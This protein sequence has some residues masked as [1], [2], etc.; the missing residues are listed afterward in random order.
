M[1]G[2]FIAQPAGSQTADSGAGITADA[3]VL[4]DAPPTISLPA[5]HD[6]CPGSTRG[7]A[8]DTPAVTLPASPGG[9]V[10]QPSVPVATLASGGAYKVTLSSDHSS[11]RYASAAVLTASVSSTVSGTGLAIGIFDLTTRSLVA[12]CSDGTGCSARYTGTPAGSHTLQAFVAPVGTQVPSVN[13][14][15]ASSA[16]EVSW[17]QVGIAS[18]VSIVGPGKSITFTATSNVDVARMGRVLELY[19]TATHSLIALCKRGTSCSAK[20][21]ESSGGVHQIVGDIPGDPEV[22]SDVA[23]TATWLGV[24]LDAGRVSP[25]SGAVTHITAVANADLSNTPWSIGIYDQS[26]HLLTSC[27]TGQTCET[28]V[29]VASGPSQSYTAMIS[30]QPAAASGG[31]VHSAAGTS[32]KPVDVQA[33]S[34]P[35][36]P[37]RLLW[38][39]DSCKMFTDEPSGEDALRLGVVLAYGTPDFWGRYLTDTVCPGITATEVAA[40]QYKHMGILPIYNDYDC[41]AVVGYQTGLGYAASAAAAAHRL[42]IPK[43]RVLMVDIEPPGAACPGAAN[44]DANFILGWF[45]GINDAGY[46][47]GYYGNGTGGSEFASA[48]CSAHDIQP[49]IA[50]N[51]FLWSF[52]PSLSDPYS[53]AGAPA[54]QPYQPGCA[55]RV[56]AWQYELSGGS[57]LDVDMDEALATLPLWFP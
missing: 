50:E 51:S 15:A 37:S 5:G 1:G 41:S 53:K 48:W 35:A 11:V 28:D 21:A 56:A 16:L 49:V 7:A 43:G 42:G 47:P 2:L 33:Q 39:V 55:A 22:E 46:V 31:S 18:N 26:G 14:Q 36:Q 40:A 23:V 29:K 57:T 30:R 3:A 44:V 38:G 8:C 4:P 6:Q 34:K 45:D 27:K 54:Y 52:E 24:T 32:N 13:V 25:Q 10:V 19:D 20:V 12:S 9:P 17:L